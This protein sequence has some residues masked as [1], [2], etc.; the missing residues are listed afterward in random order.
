VTDDLPRIDP[1]EIRKRISKQLAAAEGL[2]QFAW[3]NPASEPRARTRT[4]RRCLSRDLRA[5]DT[6]LLGRDSPV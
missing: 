5:V 6:D 4:I 2:L 1:A 3:E